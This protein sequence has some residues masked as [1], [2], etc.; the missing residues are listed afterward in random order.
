[1]FVASFL[2]IPDIFCEFLI[3]ISI[4]KV[5]NLPK[6]LAAVGNSPLGRFHIKETFINGGQVSTLRVDD[7]CPCRA[8]DVG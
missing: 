2:N 6:P 7:V 5:G 4:Q 3:I 1:M 8:N